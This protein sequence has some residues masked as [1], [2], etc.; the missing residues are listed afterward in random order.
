[1]TEDQIR[2]LTADPELADY[3]EAVVA[4]MERLARQRIAIP[5]PTV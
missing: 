4:E 2:Q 1:M 3:F 5:V